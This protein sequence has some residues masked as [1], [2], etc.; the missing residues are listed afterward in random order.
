MP[1]STV[2]RSY[3]LIHPG[4]RISLE[5]WLQKFAAKV[6][7]AEEA[8]RLIKSGCRVY[9]HPGAATPQ[10]LVDALETIREQVE[11]VEIVHILTF[12]DAPYAESS[13]GR[14]FR[15]N[16]FFAG[17]NVRDAINEGRADWTP[18]FLSEIP[19]L[20]YEG[21]M[22]IDVALVQLSPPDEH[23]FCSLGVGTEITLA[24]CRTAKAIVAEINPRMPRV[25]GDN[26]IHIS[27]ITAI[28]EVDHDLYEYHTGDIDEVSRTIGKQISELI[29]DGSTLQMGIGAI[30]DAVLHFLKEKKDIGVHTEMFSDGALELME[31][32]VINGE[33]K[34]LHR[35]KAICTFLMGSR[36]L[37]DF[38][39]NNPFIE[40]HPVE[41]VNDPFIIA[42]NDRMVAINSALSIDLT[43][44]VNADSIG[45]NIY[46]GF[47][48]QLDFIRGAARSKGGVPVVAFPSTA[49]GG[50]VSRIVGDL[51]PG[52]GVVDTRA[53]VRWVV[54]E[55]GKVNL[56]GM[57]RRQRAKALIELAHPRF[58]NELY[59]FAEKQRYI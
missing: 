44:Q 46:S 22:K 55:Y 19:R 14:S 43:G 56:F 25:L 26:F 38:V 53:D 49:K 36:R 50:T 9:I 23:G 40:S 35:G 47:G 54:T 33:K 5:T 41:Y 24:A 7:T 58:R 34:S 57:T 52:S 21:Y 17:G 11:N 32:G 1:K 30:P 20:F 12:G 45:H 27:K 3:H 18:I 15:H 4:E 28:V 37:Y 59:E 16:A 8:V 29:E 2:Q 42:Q 6:T 39:D 10:V 51:L 13:A 31:L 48:G